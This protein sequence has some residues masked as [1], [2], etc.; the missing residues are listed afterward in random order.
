LE[1]SIGYPGE[2][3]EPLPLSAIL[4]PVFEREL[5]DARAALEELDRLRA[6]AERPSIRVC[7]QVGS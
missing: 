4:I 7:L 2:E 1:W 5:R 6:A 3:K